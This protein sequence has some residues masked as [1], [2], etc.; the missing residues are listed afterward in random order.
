ML[1]CAIALQPFGHPTAGVGAA[2]A[3]ATGSTIMILALTT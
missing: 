2:I 3:V 1:D